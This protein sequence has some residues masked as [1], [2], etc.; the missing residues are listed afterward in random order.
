M[1]NFDSQLM[2]LLGERLQLSAE[3]AQEAQNHFSSMCRILEADSKTSASLLQGE[4]SDEAWRPCIAWLLKRIP[5]LIKRSETDGQPPASVP[6]SEML[7]ICHTNLVAFFKELPVVLNKVKPYLSQVT[8]N[9]GGV[10]AELQK[11]REWQETLGSL[12]HLSNKYKDLF[13]HVHCKSATPMQPMRRAG[14][15]AFLVIKAQLLPGFP[16]MVSCLELLVCVVNLLMASSTFNA[17]QLQRLQAANPGAVEG[18][19]G[20]FNTL[21]A[22]SS[23]AKVDYSKTKALMPQIEF[24]FRAHLEECDFAWL[25]QPLPAE[26]PHPQAAQIEPCCS[27][28]I[29][30]LVERPQQLSELVLSLDEAYGK[31]YMQQDAALLRQLT[32]RVN[33]NWVVLVSAALNSPLPI[34]HLGP[35]MP[36]TPISQTMG[37]VAWLSGLTK[38]LPLDPPASLTR[39][40]DAA[41][42]DAGRVLVDRVQA[43]AA[44][45]FMADSSS[46]GGG[47]AAATSGGL[48]FPELQKG[49]AQE[50]RDEQANSP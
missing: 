25:P 1:D 44:A 41:G 12:N 21:K 47:A 35:P 20:R 18:S 45:V 39:F 14:W 40:M 34:Q 10:E 49:V 11:L 4:S 38:D 7:N 8:G 19:S 5:G 29:S 46:R 31:F 36:T 2:Q 24:R 30:G 22:L 9:A 28:F 23:E 6:L 43:A 42:A 17:Q 32:N 15:L 26:L 48:K 50:R 37:S 3:Q 16:D 27:L 13:W 33:S